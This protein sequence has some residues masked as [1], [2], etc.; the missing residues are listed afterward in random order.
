MPD[1]RDD[2]PEFVDEHPAP[3][4]PDEAAFC[5]HCGGIAAA[6]ESAVSGVRVLIGQNGCIGLMSKDAKTIAAKTHLGGFGGGNLKKCE[7]HSNDGSAVPY[8]LATDRVLIEVEDSSAFQVS[9]LYSFIRKLE[10]RGQSS[11]PSVS[12][13]K[14]EHKTNAAGRDSLEIT[15]TACHQ[16]VLKSENR[17]KWTAKTIFG[18][19]PS[20]G[21]LFDPE[22]LSQRK[23]LT[24][25]FRFRYESI[26]GNLKPVKPYV[27]T[28][29]AVSLGGG[30]AVTLV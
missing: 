2:D 12:F 27:V 24:Q 30:G 1:P 28:C 23:H 16:F 18:A 26:G 25:C 8:L 14:L 29:R 10:A 9:Q 19:R 13:A 11:S 7:Q 6:S 5:T 4:C 20:S 22:G 17:E 3:P 21:L 15:P